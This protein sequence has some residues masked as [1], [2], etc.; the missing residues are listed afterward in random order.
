MASTRERFRSLSAR[1]Y[2]AAAVAIVIVIYFL[3]SWAKWW[4]GV[5]TPGPVLDGVLFVLFVYAV[6]IVAT[7][8][9]KIWNTAVGADGRASTSKFQPFLWTIVVLFAYVVVT[10]IRFASDPSTALPEIPT[11]VLIVLGLAFGTGIGAKL[12]TSNRLDSGAEV[13]DTVDHKGA[14][15]LFQS[16]D[17]YPDLYKIQTLAF[18]FIGVG[19]YLAQVFAAV[20]ANTAADTLPDIPEGLLFL[21]GIG[22]AAYLAKK[23]AGGKVTH[24]ATIDP[25]SVSRGGA[26][27]ARTV[28]VSGSNLGA[29]QGASQIA[30]DGTVLQTVATSWSDSSITFVVPKTRPDGSAWTLDEPLEVRVVA[31]APSITAVHLTITA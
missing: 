28:T 23:L 1:Q 22:N 10:S 30:I 14:A 12:I 4:T 5:I 11:N 8:D 7:D 13:R 29:S 18:T 6:Y 16:D 31:G 26:D 21:M 17:G 3:N 9:E 19:T 2:V 24:L 27:A 20:E 25:P 15:P